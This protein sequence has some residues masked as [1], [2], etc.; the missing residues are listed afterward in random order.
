MGWI[1]HNRRDYVFDVPYKNVLAIPIC[2]DIIGGTKAPPYVKFFILSYTDG[3]HIFAHNLLG[4]YIVLM[5]VWHAGLRIRMKKRPNTEWNVLRTWNS[6]CVEWNAIRSWNVYFGNVHRKLFKKYQEVKA[7]N[8]TENSFK[9]DR[10]QAKY[11]ILKY[12]WYIQC[13]YSDSN[14]NSLLG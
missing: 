13:R 9:A 14:S 12:V 11:P 7:S 1:Y 5:K 4:W 2:S 6:T 3:L 10:N 8:E